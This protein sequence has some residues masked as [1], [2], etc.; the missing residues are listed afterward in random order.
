MIIGKKLTSD[1]KVLDIVK[2]C[3]IEFD[4]DKE[5]DLNFVSNQTVFNENQSVIIADEIKKLVGKNVL[6][7]VQ[8][9]HG[10]FL[11]P[12]F[13]RPKKNGE[14]RM[15]LNFKK[16][17]ENVKYYHFKMDTFESAI[18]LITKGTFVA[19]VDLRHAYYS[20]NMAPE[21][22]IFFKIYVGNNIYQY[23]C[24]P[25]GL[26]CAP[27]FFLTKLMK[28]V[29]AKL[30]SLG[31]FTVCYIDDSLLCGDTKRECQK[32]VDNIFYERIGFYDKCRTISSGSTR[33][34]NL[35]M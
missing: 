13:L 14:F 35:F 27:R 5:V 33:T 24:L 4:E 26:A 31:L 12:I 3:H 9:C 1:S 2:N 29:Y 20:V 6:I 22:Q 7:E 17:N 25:N 34:N 15:I 18:Q 16:F 21:H 30:R 10:Q 11:S 28:P 19:S 8:E 32:N 23:T